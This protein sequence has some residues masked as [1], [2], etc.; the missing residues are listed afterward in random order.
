MTDWGQRIETRKEVERRERKVLNTS[1]KNCREKKIVDHVKKNETWWKIQRVIGPTK[2]KG[3]K[4]DQ[5][6]FVNPKSWK[7]KDKRPELKPGRKM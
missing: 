3:R 5:E 7:M 2:D 4:K 1:L 6:L